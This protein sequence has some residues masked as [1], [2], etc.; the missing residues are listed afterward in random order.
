MNLIYPPTLIPTIKYK[1]L[2]L[3]T[4]VFRDAANNIS[5]YTTF[6]NDLKSNGVTLTTI[7]LVKFEL[8][9]GS[10][11]TAKY[12]ATEKHIDDITNKTTLPINPRNCELA[13]DLIKL[14]G[15][16]GSAMHITD[17]FLGTI[18]M[19]YGENIYLMTR[20]TSDF[21]QRIFN[22]RFVINATHA[23]GIFTY[24]IYQYTK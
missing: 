21:L 24:G 4:N 8:L 12:Q 3:D 9:K 13:Y 10:T 6:F 22:L 14:Y 7:D 11:N 2:L 19:Q 1:H 17:L 23:K 5:T 15:I 20:D 16:D 18:L